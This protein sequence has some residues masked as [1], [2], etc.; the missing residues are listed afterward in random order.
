MM[1]EAMN[2]IPL[3]QPIKVMSLP[4]GERTIKIGAGTKGARDFLVEKCGRFGNL[5]EST[6][7]P[8][9]FFLTVSMAYNEWEVMDYI[10]SYTE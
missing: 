2:A 4:V 6:T 3:P 1:G 8:G 5:T 7:V 10:Q 9:D